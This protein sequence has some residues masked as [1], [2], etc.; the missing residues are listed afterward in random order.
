MKIDL[1]VHT[2]FS[3]DS[4][5]SL[6][7]AVAAARR[8][9]L[10]GIAV[11]NHNVFVPPPQLDDFV[12]IPACEYSTDAGHIITYFISEALDEGLEKDSLGRFRWQ[13]ILCRARSAGAL[14]FLAH[15]YAP[16]HDV[17][18]IFE[19]IDGIEAY[20]ARIEHSSA[21]GA[22]A[23][24]QKTAQDLALPFSAGSDAH[25]PAE[26]GA[27]YW[28]YDACSGSLAEIRT[29]LAD[30][31][32]RIFGGTAKAWWRPMSAWISAIGS[33]RLRGMP[34]LALRTAKAL[35]KSVSPNRK[36]TLIDMKGDPSHEA[37]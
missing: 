34:K 9:G 3:A 2:E 24:A 14:A 19:H 7:A 4:R 37:V 23:M 21:R 25:F 26:V 11:A 27:A 17:A 31:R 15:P 10:G 16:R 32:G 29:A 20:N 33:K 13:D 36:P 6:E 22:N 28:E 1:H 30:G 35:I 18:E 5:M 8:K 12:I